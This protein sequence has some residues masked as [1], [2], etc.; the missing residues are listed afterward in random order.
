MATETTLSPRDLLRAATLG[1]PRARTKELAEVNGVVVE[2]RRPSVGE[3]YE[4]LDF[5]KAEKGGAINM[6]RLHCAAIVRLVVVPDTD[7]RVYEDADMDG[8]LASEAGGW[9]DKLFEIAGKL[10]NVK[11]DDLAKNSEAPQSD[12]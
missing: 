4:I 1:A 5:A 7:V 12:N 11:S 9:S 2:V 10:M 3:R 8:L 6:R